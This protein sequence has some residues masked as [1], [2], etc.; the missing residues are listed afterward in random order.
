MPNKSGHFV[1]P[2]PPSNPKDAIPTQSTSLIASKLQWS[3]LT[4]LPSPDTYT[5]ETLAQAWD[6]ALQQLQTT[7]LAQQHWKQN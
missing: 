6:E 1:I 3:L 7:A 5:P 4:R 2:P